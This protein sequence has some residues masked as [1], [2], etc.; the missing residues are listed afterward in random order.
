[1][2]WHQN[3]LS[4]HESFSLELSTSLSGAVASEAICTSFRP[5]PLPPLC[6]SSLVPQ[7][8][9]GLFCF[10]NVRLIRMG[11]KYLE[12]CCLYLLKCPRVT[13][14]GCIQATSGL[15]GCTGV[16]C[17]VGELEKAHFQSSFPTGLEPVAMAESHCPSRALCLE[18]SKTQ[19]QRQGLIFKQYNT[20]GYEAVCGYPHW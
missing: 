16:L 13:V 15:Q 18:P 20:S 1:M 7:S 11:Q 8:I 2:S 12:H 9:S 5:A 3:V 6:N 10:S 4:E 19:T 14:Q 17:A